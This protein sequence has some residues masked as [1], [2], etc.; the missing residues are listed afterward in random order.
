MLDVLVGGIPV[1]S[2]RG[3]IAPGVSAAVSGNGV[4]VAINN[5]EVAVASGG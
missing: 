5:V 2:G 4:S 3:V 1:T